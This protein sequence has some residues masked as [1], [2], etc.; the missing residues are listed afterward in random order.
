MKRSLIVL[1]LVMILICPT[2]RAE[3][4]WSGADK[5]AHAGVSF[6]LSTLAYNAFREKA[7]MSDKAARV[8]AFAATMAVGLAKELIDDEVSG[9]DLA[10]DA[11]GA[12][13][14]AVVGIKFRF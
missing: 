14:G 12:G 10:A 9:K 8:A 4:R 7:G 5:L 3:D 11:A 6:G 1:I 2:V 13:L